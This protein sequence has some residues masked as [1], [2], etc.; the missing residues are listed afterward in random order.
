MWRHY[1]DAEKDSV[2]QYAYTTSITH[3]A[4]ETGMSRP[5]IANHMKKLGLPIRRQGNYT[6][7]E[8]DHLLST[9]PL[10]PVLGAKG[11]QHK[12]W[13][14]L[15][16][17]RSALGVSDVVDGEANRKCGGRCPAHSVDQDA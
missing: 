11:S 13:T 3:A 14:R 8:I 16:A 5:V 17:R 12:R 7:D 4:E 9:R 2:A 6:N 10:P 1:T 15:Q